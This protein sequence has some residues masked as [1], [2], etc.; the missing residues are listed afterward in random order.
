MF[1]QGGFSIE[2]QSRIAEEA[3]RY[4]ET[5]DSRRQGLG[6]GLSSTQSKLNALKARVRSRERD[7]PSYEKGRGHWIR[8]DMKNAKFA[9]N[10][11]FVVPKVI[12]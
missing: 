6:L 8:D 9:Y 2:D 5:R 7:A 12:E 3:E 4:A 11:Y 1:H 10:D